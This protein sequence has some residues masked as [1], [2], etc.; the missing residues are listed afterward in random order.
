MLTLLN[1]SD[2]NSANYVDDGANYNMI[3]VSVGAGETSTN[4]MF[5]D[6]LASSSPSVSGSRTVSDASSGSPSITAAPTMSGAPGVAPLGSISGFWDCE[7]GREQRQL[8][9]YERV[10]RVDCSV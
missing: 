6:A 8:E 5:V 4:N 10:G 2:T 3:T 9:G 1:E 7:G